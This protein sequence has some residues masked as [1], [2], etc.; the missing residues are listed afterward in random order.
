[1]IMRSQGRDLCQDRAA[2][3]MLCHRPTSERLLTHS[4]CLELSLRNRLIGHLRSPRTVMTVWMHPWMSRRGETVEVNWTPKRARYSLQNWL[5][6]MGPI[7]DEKRFTKSASFYEYCSI[8]SAVMRCRLTIC[9][10]WHT[11]RWSSARKCS[12]CPTV[13]SPS[14]I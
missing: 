7:T 2:S 13:F 10:R 14:S 11:Y 9:E 4:C 3:R 12:R 5:P 1:M 8:R 6:M